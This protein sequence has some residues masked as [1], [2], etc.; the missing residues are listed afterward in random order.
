[1]QRLPIWVLNHRFPSVYDSESKT[2]IEQTARVYGAMQDLIDEYN[3]FAETTNKALEMFETD[4]VDSNSKFKKEICSIVENYI[5][6]IDA[7]LSSFD[8]KINEAIADIEGLKD[9][10]D[11]LETITFTINGKTYTSKKGTT[12][13]EWVVDHT[14]EYMIGS[15]THSGITDEISSVG[16]GWEYIGTFNGPVKITEVI[17]NGYDYILV[18]PYGG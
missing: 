1:M 5:T 7:K 11:I 2:A 9:R 14:D 6:S 13:G 12:W 4:M 16:K 10:I 18:S 8:R 17:E 3:K 15:T